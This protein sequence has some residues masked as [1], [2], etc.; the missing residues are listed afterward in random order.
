M[1]NP[2]PCV[3]FQ[4]AALHQSESCHVP[5]MGGNTTLESYYVYPTFQAYM[6]TL[7]EPSA[8]WLTDPMEVVIR[9]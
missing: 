6:Q 7:T 3:G 2:V 8:F 9:T 4:P 5:D 1:F